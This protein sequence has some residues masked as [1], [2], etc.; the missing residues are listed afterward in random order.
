LELVIK[1]MRELIEWIELCAFETL[2]DSEL[3]AKYSWF[4]SSFASV[5]PKCEIKEFRLQ[6][7]IE[8]L[9]LTGFVRTGLHITDRAFPVV[10]RGS[11]VHLKQNQVADKDMMPTMQMLGSKIGI[12]RQ[13]YLKNLC[14]EARPERKEV[15]DVFFKWQSLF[16]L[17]PYGVDGKF[18]VFRKHYG[19]REWVK[20]FPV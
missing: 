17:L 13:S 2:T 5:C 7:M 1:V 18:A 3:Q 12:S 16:L 15:W 14:C 20:L 10:G 19:E 6:L 4:C 9:V 11:Y 8:L